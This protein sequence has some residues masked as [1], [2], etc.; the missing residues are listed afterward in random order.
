MITGRPLVNRAGFSD[1][2]HY[3]MDEFQ[4]PDQRARRSVRYH[5]PQASQQ[6]SWR[7]ILNTTNSNFQEKSSLPSIMD[8][9]VCYTKLHPFEC[10]YLR[11]RQDFIRIWHFLSYSLANVLC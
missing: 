9:Q 11:R 6:I 1:E 10:T 3:L 5:L 2:V 4:Y 7:H 8:I